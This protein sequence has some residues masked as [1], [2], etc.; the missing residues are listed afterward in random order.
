MDSSNQTQD[1]RVH[2][3]DGRL[4]PVQPAR[5]WVVYS[6]HVDRCV[7][8]VLRSMMSYYFQDE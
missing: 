4:L 1:L 6:L 8:L 3:A 5:T 2:K 7:L